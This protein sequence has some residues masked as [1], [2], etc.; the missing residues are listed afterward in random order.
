[1]P[2]QGADPDRHRTVRLDRRSGGDGHRVARD[3]EGQPRALLRVDHGG[4]RP[5]LLVC[6]V[7]DPISCRARQHHRPPPGERPP[8]APLP[9]GPVVTTAPVG[10]RW[11]ARAGRDT[12]FTAVTWASRTGPRVVAARAMGTSSRVSAIP[13]P[14]AS[15]A[16]LLIPITST[17]L[18][19]S[20]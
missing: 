1:R 2:G 12:P 17:G 18:T 14:A 13:V 4:A 3:V 11:P 20:A 10:T 5:P 9:P 16:R 15:T 7:E 19:P 6:A 8:P